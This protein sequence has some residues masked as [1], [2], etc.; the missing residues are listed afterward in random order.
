MITRRTLAIGAVLTPA[1]L[2]LRPAR[3]AAE[4]SLQTS[5]LVY[6]TPIKSNGQE[7]RCKSEIWFTHL[8]NSVFV[9]TDSGAWRARALDLGLNRARIWVGEFGTWKE[10]DGAFRQGPELMAT[11]SLEADAEVQARVLEAMGGKYDGDGW[12]NWGPRFKTS[13]ADGSRVMIRY[14]LDA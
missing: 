5:K 11:G 13:L 14:A 7:S 4:D 12:S 6:L 2:L 9:V 3:G 10:A 8:D 1:F